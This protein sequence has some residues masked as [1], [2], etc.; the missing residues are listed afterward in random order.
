MAS[1]I[2][3]TTKYD[4]TVSASPAPAAGRARRTVDWRL[5]L[6]AVVLLSAVYTAWHLGRGWV[7]HDEGTLG[8]SA[9]RL[10]QGELPHRDFDEL[11][12]GGLTWV[13][14][15]AFS[16]FGTTLFVLRIVLLAAFVAWVPAVFY[17]A[18]RFVRPLAAAGVTL[19][20]VVW[21]VPNYTAP[22]PSWYNL[23]LTVFGLA[24]LLRWIED[25][26]P[27]WLIAAGVA[28]GLSLLVKVV[29]L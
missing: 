26:R 9:E 18:S 21:S 20:C 19:L 13:N 22:L 7:A 17:V 29:G 25:R 3:P 8:Q 2:V 28:G 6:L 27:R 14:A 4:P 12:T 16:A 11:Y 10:L 5:L 23:F 1:T 15:A 24:A